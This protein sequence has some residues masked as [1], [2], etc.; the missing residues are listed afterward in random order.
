MLDPVR[1]RL[2]REF[3]EHGT[4]TAVA[5]VCGL[6]SSAVS[7]QLAA[8]EREAGVPL[9]ERAGRRVRLTAEGWRLV[10]HARIVLSALDAA[11]QDLRS[12]STPRGPVRVA[13]FATAAVARLLP[14]IATARARH[15]DL[16]VIVHELEPREAVEALRAGRCDLAIAFTYNLIPEEPRPGLTRRFV[17]VEPMLTALPAAHPAAAGGVDLRALGEEPWIA[18]SEGTSDHEMLD[19]ACARAGFRPNV[20]HTADDYA[21]VLRMVREGLGVA[22]VPELVATAVGVPGGVVLRPVSGVEITRTTYAHFRTATPAIDAMIE[23]IYNVKAP[24]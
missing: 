6:T 3:A 8:L 21:L 13:C 20:I 16:H 23:L 2:L 18:G 1:L 22:L 19:R 4:M 12:A 5:E 9:F 14:A 17:G 7:Q 24:D 15:P 11:E 10:R